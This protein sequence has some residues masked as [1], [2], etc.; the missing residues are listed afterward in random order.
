MQQTNP[1][2]NKINPSPL[3][4]LIIAFLRIFFNLLYHPFA[5]TYDGVAYVV[6]LGRWQSWIKTVLPYITGPTVLEIGFGP[7]HLQETL[8]H[9]NVTA[10]GIDESRQMTRLA[11]HRLLRQGVRP[12]LVRGK[13]QQLPFLDCSFYQV[14]MTF[15]AEFLLSEATYSEIWRVLNPGGTVIIVPMAWLTG[16]RPVERMAAWVNRIAGQAPAWDERY[17]EPLMDFGFDVSWEMI[18]V[19]ASRVLLI[20]L[21][22]PAKHPANP[23]ESGEILL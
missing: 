12:N 15:P 1:S 20:R 17:L 14:V 13:A 23:S 3:S 9:M 19:K 11:S 6:S 5:W 16:S 8:E 4:R 18:D 21:M 10:F 2:I 22:K 7:G